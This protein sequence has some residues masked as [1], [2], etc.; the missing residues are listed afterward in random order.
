[1]SGPNYLPS[2][3]V[4]RRLGIKTQTLAKWRMEGKGPRG[5]FHLS[6][7]RCLYAED[8]VE[9]FIRE[10]AATRPEFNLPRPTGG[11]KIKAASGVMK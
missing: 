6:P 4:A 2:G 5:W 7:T 8:A 1:M 9:E 3:V 10:K 11:P